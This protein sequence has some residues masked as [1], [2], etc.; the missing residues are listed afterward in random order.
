M[1]NQITD[2]KSVKKMFIFYAKRRK[3]KKTFPYFRSFS[4]CQKVLKGKKEN[5]KKWKGGAHWGL[6]VM[7]W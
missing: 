1:T 3:R 4:V 2:E 7:D 5:K 6:D